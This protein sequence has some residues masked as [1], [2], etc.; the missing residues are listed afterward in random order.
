MNTP[1]RRFIKTTACTVLAL[2]VWSLFIPHAQGAEKWVD[3]RV[4]GP[5]V[6][7]ADFP[8]AGLEEQLQELKQLQTDLNRSLGIRPPAEA[9]NVYLFQNERSYRNYMARHLPKMP[10]RPAL[11]DKNDGPGNVYVF[12]NHDFAV[13]LRHECT[14]ALLHATL[15]MVPLWLDEG[16]AKYFELPPKQRASENPY[17]KSVRWAV[18][19]GLFSSLED[20]ERENDFSKMGRN[21]YRD[22][23]AWVHFMLHGPAEARHE[24]IRYLADIQASTPPGV[25]SQRLARRMPDVRSRVAGH[26]KSW[27]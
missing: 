21:D 15:P 20:L 7:R 6:V 9:I 4:V 14:H 24:L 5:F 22:S 10:Y 3:V 17:L 23:W 11:Y 13:N 27:K 2:T 26:F 1:P 18:R 16:L 12:R 25:L 19:F 8:L